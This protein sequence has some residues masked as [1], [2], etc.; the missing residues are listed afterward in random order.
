MKYVLSF[1]LLTA[2][3]F[4]SLAKDDFSLTVYETYADYQNKSGKSLYEFIGYDWTMGSLHLFFRVKKKE[5]SKVKVTTVWGF[6]IGDQLYRVMDGRPYRVLMQGKVVY[7]E[8]GVAHLNM[9]IGDEKESDVELG[10]YSFL[11]ENLNSEI[12][13][14][15][16]AKAG[17]AFGENAALKP[18]FECVEK[19]KKNKTE[20]IREC[21]KENI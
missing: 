16:S 9:L 2:I 19:V 18:L 10:G 14:F 11:S 12:I 8:N 7:C 3:S 6:T 13:E 21:V 5:E 17:K 15:P 1:F 20:K 4:Q